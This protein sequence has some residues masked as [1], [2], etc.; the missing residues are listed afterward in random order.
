MK[1]LL[2]NAGLRVARWYV[3]HHAL[4]HEIDYKE[5]SKS[6]GMPVFIKPANL[7]S[8]VGISKVDN[9][10]AF[11]DAIALAFQYDG[12]IL[13]EEAIDGRE[14]E[15][16][17]LGNE[18]PIA[19][20]PGEVV[21]RTE[22]YSYDAKYIDEDS[23]LLKI[24]ASLPDTVLREIQN[25]AVNVFKILCC[26]GMARVD[27]FINKNH[28]IIVNEINT[29]PGFTSISMYPK[30][31]EKSGM[32]IKELID[33]LIHLALERHAGVLKLHSSIS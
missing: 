30:L 15:C 24:P 6:L 4:R 3:A 19:S 27:F 32:P 13:I 12:K 11:K 5:I 26:A 22:F 9:I 29:I 31:W 28:H 33:R 18:D 2:Q 20:L 1:R 7:G 8:S 14:I 17:V 23:A 10:R 21:S 25:N 16:A